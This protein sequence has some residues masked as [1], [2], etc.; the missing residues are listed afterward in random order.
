MRTNKGRRIFP[1][2]IFSISLS[3]PTFPNPNITHNPLA[4]PPSWKRQGSYTL[5]AALGRLHRSRLSH[6]T[7]SPWLD[8]GKVAPLPL[9]HN[10]R[11]SGGPLPLP[12]INTRGEGHKR[13]KNKGGGFLER[14]REKGTKKNKGIE[15][16]TEKRD[17]KKRE[18]EQQRET[19]EKRK[20]QK[21]KRKVKNK[22]KTEGK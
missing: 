17:E 8:R 2:C 20:K 11:G 18:G 9:H 5:R 6:L 10:W 19:R 14:I 15:R 22:E 12:L 4:L 1:P 16:G 21:V 3:L 13:K 7:L